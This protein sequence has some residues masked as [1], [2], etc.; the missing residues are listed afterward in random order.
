VLGWFLVF[1]AAYVILASCFKVLQVR[2]KKAEFLQQLAEEMQRM[3]MLEK[4]MKDAAADL[5]AL[6][7][8]QHQ[9]RI[10]CLDAQVIAASSRLPHRSFSA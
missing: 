5:A 2:R 10:S 3:E 7:S 1:L 4:L 6:R 8:S 9:N